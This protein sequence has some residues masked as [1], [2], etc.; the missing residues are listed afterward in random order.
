MDRHPIA[1]V[2]D[3]SARRRPDGMSRFL[4]IA[5]QVIR[6]VLISVLIAGVASQVHAQD[7]TPDGARADSIGRP[8][9]QNPSPMVEH[10]RA[11]D[12]L[13]PGVQPGVQ[14]SIDADLPQ[15][16]TFFIR[17]GV[18]S[19]RG[20]NLLIHFLG[21]DYIPIQAISAAESHEIVAVVNLGGGSS[22]YEHPFREEGVFNRLLDSLAR[23]AHDE[24]D[25]PVRFDRVDLSAFSAG[26]GAVRAILADG[27]NRIRGIL[28]L[29]GLHTGYIPERKVLA[30][31]GRLDTTLLAPFLRFARLAVAGEKALVLTHSEIFPGTFASTTETSDYLVERL[32]LERTAVLEWGPGGMQQ[33]SEVH[34]GRFQIRGF[35]GNTAPDH[36]DHLHGMAEFLPLLHPE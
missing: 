24:L 5:D 15:P 25:E 16:V 21:A 11:H 8:A 2:P 3:L 28:L 10:T 4:C 34:A 22:A 19:D 7:G 35:A 30:E 26:Y 31:G 18:T 36:L 23:A 27:A 13:S 17:E 14:R 33:V 6:T 32:G 12:R 9:S 20:L 1:H 29:D